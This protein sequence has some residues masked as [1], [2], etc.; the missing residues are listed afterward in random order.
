MTL[1]F[2]VTLR[3]IEEMD[4]FNQLTVDW[5]ISHSMTNINNLCKP[6]VLATSLNETFSVIWASRYYKMGSGS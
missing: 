1:S 5:F 3:I 6:I 2:N 4:L